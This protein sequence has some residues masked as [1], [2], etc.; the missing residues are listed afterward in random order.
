MR[1]QVKRVK[2][3][4]QPL[5]LI[6]LKRGFVSKFAPREDTKKVDFTTQWSVK[7]SFVS[8][9]TRIFLFQAS[10]KVISF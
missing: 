9:L 7:T 1:R 3:C 5:D 2:R 10:L 8:Y 6:L 4:C